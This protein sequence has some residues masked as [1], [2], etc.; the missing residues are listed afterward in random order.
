[1][2]AKY[3]WLDNLTLLLEAILDVMTL[4][5]FKNENWELERSG[6]HDVHTINVCI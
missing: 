6:V 5:W 2:A 1:M 3:E 4:D